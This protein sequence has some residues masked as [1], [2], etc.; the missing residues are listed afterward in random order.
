MSE[1]ENKALLVCFDKIV[2][3]ASTAVLSIDQSCLRLA[4]VED[5][6]SNHILTWPN[7]IVGYHAF[8][9]GQLKWL[10]V[11]V[12]PQCSR[13][14]ATAVVP[15]GLPWLWAKNEHIAAHRELV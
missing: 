15:G 10:V 13:C 5:A 6:R 7:V 12:Q 8:M 14:C 3:D 11:C 4:R 9:N 1:C 2:A